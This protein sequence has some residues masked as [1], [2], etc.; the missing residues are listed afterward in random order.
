MKFNFINTT[1]LA[2]SLFVSSLA[3]ADTIA[4]KNGTIFLLGGPTLSVQQLSDSLPTAA[5]TDQLAKQPINKDATDIIIS[6]SKAIVAPGT[7]AVTADVVDIS[8]CLSPTHDDEEAKAD[9]KTG[10]LTIPCLNV[11]NAM[12]NVQMKQRGNSMNWEVE[13]GEPIALGSCIK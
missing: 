4:E 13:F 6:G 8:L 2:S 9:L 5:C 1:I 3:L 12:Y 11:D 10:V 7:T